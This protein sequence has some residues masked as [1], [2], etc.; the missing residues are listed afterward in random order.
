MSKQG[1]FYDNQ[2]YYKGSF[3]KT[4]LVQQVIY[5]FSHLATDNN[6]KII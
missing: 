5:D 3:D 1:E 6:D 4:V 2:W